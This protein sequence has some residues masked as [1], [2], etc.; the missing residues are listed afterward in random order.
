MGEFQTLKFP[1]IWNNS[2]ITK[3][4][5]LILQDAGMEKRAFWGAAWNIAKG[6]GSALGS[7]ARSGAGYVGNKLQTFGTALPNLVSFN[8][9]QGGFNKMKGALGPNMQIAN[10]DAQTAFNAGLK[11]FAI[12]G[13]KSVATIGTPMYIGGKMLFGG[14]N[15]QP[16]QPMTAPQPQMYNQAMPGTYS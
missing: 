2:M 1:H 12:G 5:Y 9:A 13:A 4:A 11:D 16:Q 14:N 10:K 7:F 8:Q 3:Q 15:A 6:V